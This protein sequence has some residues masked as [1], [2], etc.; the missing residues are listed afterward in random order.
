MVVDSFIFFEELDLLELRLTILDAV[1]D[2]FVVVEGTRTFS[3]KEKPLHFAAH[4]ERFAKWLPRIDYV[5]VDDWPV[6]DDPWVR[7]NFQRNAIARG[8]EHLQAEDTVILSDLDEIPKPQAVAAN[9]GKGGYMWFMQC[10]HRG[11]INA[12][13]VRRPIWSSGSRMFSLAAFRRIAEM[14]DFKYNKFAPA[15][16]NEGATC[17]KARRLRGAVSIPDGGWHFSYLGGIESIIRK[18]QAYSHQ[19]RNTPEFLDPARLK[20]MLLEGRDVRKGRPLLISPVEELGLSEAALRV[21]AAH[22]E[23]VAPVQPAA[24]RARLER[25]LRWDMFKQCAFDRHF[26]MRMLRRWLPR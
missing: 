7:E 25:Q 14:K 17:V 4:R 22:P 21:V 13:T 5:V 11:F 18:I 10:D 19:E 23:W 1:V 8:W 15:A 2:R 26:V 3:G 24:V 9:A 16:Y 20:Q 6:T 12:Q